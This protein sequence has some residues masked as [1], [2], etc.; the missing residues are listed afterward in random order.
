MTVDQFKFIYYFEYAHRMLG[1]A[2][3]VG[4]VL[5]AV[6]FWQRGRFSSHMKL[7]TLLIGALIGFQGFLGWYMVKSGLDGE[8][9]PTKKHHA[10]PRVSHYRLTSH[11]G[12]AF[13]IYAT[14]LWSYFGYTKAP[15][16]LSPTSGEAQGMRQRA[17]QMVRRLKWASPLTTA[18][19]FTTAMSGA[20]VAGLNAGHIYNEFPL[21]GGQIM[22]PLNDLFRFKPAILNFFQNATMVQFQHRI[23][24]S[25]SLTAVLALCVYVRRGAIWKF[26]P[27]QTKV[28]VCLLAVFAT[29]QYLIGLNTLLNNVPVHSA[30]AHQTG[31][32]ALFGVALWLS[33]QMKRLPK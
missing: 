9:D 16:L 26:L 33:H 22:P 30:S 32:F 1:R 15:E 20:L 13:V 21:M 17:M 10:I 27:R 18:L 14:L 7:K 19:I 4:F 29:L 3:G 25:A 5:P 12:T 23:L 8:S 24:A 11:L 6:Y 2:I 28:A 31:A